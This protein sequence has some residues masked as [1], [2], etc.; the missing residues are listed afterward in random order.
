MC[1]EKSCCWR[2]P[3]GH[4]HLQLRPLG[5]SCLIPFSV[6]KAELAT[7]REME[8]CGGA[9]GGL[10]T[11]DPGRGGLEIPDL[12]EE[13][14]GVRGIP[15]PSPRPG[16]P[17]LLFP[18]RASGEWRPGPA[19]PLRASALTSLGPGY[20]TCGRSAQAR[21]GGGSKGLLGPGN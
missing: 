2:G 14:L 1:A 21:G 4:P 6:D 15:P 8:G 5:L 10:G 11:Q 13:D 9:G 12:R 7:G 18:S 16:P 3:R 19:A 17:D 20:A